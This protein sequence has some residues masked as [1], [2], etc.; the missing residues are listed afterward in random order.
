M[1]FPAQLSL[2]VITVSLSIAGLFALG[3][4]GET[5]Q[6]QAKQLP[7]KTGRKETE[8]GDQ[9]VQPLQ[10]GQQA[11]QAR[12]LELALSLLPTQS[13]FKLALLGELTSAHPFAEEDF[14][15]LSKQEALRCQQEPVPPVVALGTLQPMTGV[16]PALDVILDHLVAVSPSASTSFFKC[17]AAKIKASGGKEQ[18]DQRGRRIDGPAG[19]LYLHS[20]GAL[21]FVRNAGD[22]PLVK[23]RLTH[24]KEL[25][26]LQN[27]NTQTQTE[28]SVVLTLRP[29]SAWLS[30][31]AQQ[32]AL[33]ELSSLRRLRL[34]LIRS[35]RLRIHCITTLV[36][37]AA[38]HAFL[39][40]T[41]QDSAKALEREPSVQATKRTSPLRLMVQTIPPA[42][43]PRLLALLGYSSL[44]E[45]QARQERSEAQMTL[46]F[47][48]K[49]AGLSSLLQNTLRS[50]SQP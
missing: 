28:L 38:F 50:A 20:N 8:P 33:P 13:P 3:Q 47:D 10:P 37:A 39:R 49:K 4:K 43:R 36:G 42:L 11:E 14:S 41:L 26:A 16:E 15:L 18:L 19:S 34:E 23:E 40:K 22:L 27:S 30:T 32:S 48:L 9:Q 17:A 45:P 25:Q 35:E 44:S 6:V 5:E 1:K 7:Q 46:E 24:L 31:W 29:E 2:A 12:S 21:A